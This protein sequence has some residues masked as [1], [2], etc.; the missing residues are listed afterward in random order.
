MHNSTLF[1]D[2]LYFLQ[3]KKI[4]KIK[5]VFIF[6]TAV[7]LWTTSCSE[8]YS[9][10]GTS[11]KIPLVWTSFLSCASSMWSLQFL[12]WTVWALTSLCNILSSYTILKIT[13]NHQVLLYFIFVL[14]G[15]FRIA[16]S[17][18]FAWINFLI[19][20]KFYGNLFNLAFQTE[21]SGNYFPL[22]WFILI[23]DKH[24]RFKVLLGKGIW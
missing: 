14:I 20:S 24:F 23:A 9:L 22:K 19:C 16:Q 18:S 5:L 2:A 3:L 8:H 7:Q 11:K 1:Y 6:S 10:V 13:A 17:K 4:L 12:T 15:A 21:L